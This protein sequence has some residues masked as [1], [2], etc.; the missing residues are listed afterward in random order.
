VHPSKESVLEDLKTHDIAHFACHGESVPEDPSRSCLLLYESPQS[1]SRLTVRSLSN[2]SHDKAQI[3]YLSACCTAQ[4]YALG[5]VDEAIHLGSTFQLIGFP[6]VIATLW[7]AEDLAA[8]KV[9]GAFYQ[10]LAQSG[11]GSTGDHTAAR[12]LHQAVKGL[13]TKTGRRGNPADDV[14]AW[15]PFVHIGA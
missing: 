12:C 13:W 3:A 10:G 4:H 1:V 2:I 9:A 5:L 11:D 15:A 8:V 14:L 7:E 6:S